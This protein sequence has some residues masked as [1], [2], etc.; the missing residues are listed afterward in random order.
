MKK[1]RKKKSKKSK[2]GTILIMI[3]SI[4]LLSSIGIYLIK[5]FNNDINVTLIDNLNIEVNSELKI[6]SLIKNIENGKLVEENELLDTDKIGKKKVT[7]KI[8]TKNEKEEKYNFTVNIIDSENPVIECDEKIIIGTG[9]EV[10]LLSYAKASDNYDENLDIKVEGTYDNNINGEY[11]L[12]YVVKDSSQNE[13]K[14]EFTLVVET[15]KYKRMA[16][17]TFTTDKGYTL[18]IIN[19]VAYIDGIL[20]ANKTYYLPENYTP[21]DSYATLS[22][23]CANCLEKEVMTAYN[24]MKADTKSLGLNIW[25]ASGYRSYTTQN[26]L[27]NNYV[28]RDG[29]KAAD[30][31]SE[32]PGYS[33]HQTGIA[34]D[35]NSVDESFAKTNEGKWIKDNCHLYGFII[36]YPEGKEEITGYMYESWHLRY[37]GKEL[38]KTLYNNGN[39][40]TIEEHFGIT[41]EYAG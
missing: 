26:Y 27:Y 7:I 1:R 39:W 37:V 2:I 19:G 38:A 36:R 8:K 20:I 29:K 6:S 14:K 34:F 30:T 4:I 23:N 13:V 5:E 24:E 10:D 28:S 41:S 31:Y 32:R 15:P 33:E 18:K 22:S 12:T 35:L 11:S 16:D 40:L 3:F 17:K 9:D 25:I 21:K